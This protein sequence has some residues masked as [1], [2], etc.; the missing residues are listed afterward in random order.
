MSFKF[1]RREKKAA[2]RKIAEE[3]TCASA[4][5]STSFKWIRFKW[6]SCSDLPHLLG[7][8]GKRL[9]RIQEEFK[10]CKISII[11]ENTVSYDYR[12]EMGSRREMS[13]LGDMATLLSVCGAIEM[14]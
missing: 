2:D 9:K 7:K 13:I 3:A 6:I 12:A 14:L 8:Q 4:V 11:D 10:N 1:V 5:K